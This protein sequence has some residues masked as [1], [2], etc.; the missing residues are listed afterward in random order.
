MSD[1]DL[2]A[3]IERQA[4]EIE[5][6]RRENVYLKKMAELMPKQERVNLLESMCRAVINCG[7]GCS[8][9]LAHRWLE[10]EQGG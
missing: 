6:L 10:S 2:L 7:A 9:S 4:V 8:C 5:D 1:A 3:R